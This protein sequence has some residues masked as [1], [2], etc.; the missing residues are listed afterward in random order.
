MGDWET[1]TKYNGSKYWDF[2]GGDA[3]INVTQGKSLKD[4]KIDAVTNYC[5]NCKGFS[6]GLKITW[7]KN[8]K[9]KPYKPLTNKSGKN[10]KTISH[11]YPSSG[12]YEI[13]FYTHHWIWAIIIPIPI[14]AHHKFNITV[15]QCRSH[16]YTNCALTTLTNKT[17]KD[18]YWYDSC[19]RKE[20]IKEKCKDEN[21]CTLNTCKNKKCN[22]TKKCDGSTCELN[23]T[24]GSDWCEYCG[25][26]IEL[27]CKDKIDNDC[28]SKVDLNDSDC[29]LRYQCE[30]GSQRIGDVNNDDEINKNDSEIVSRI[31]RGIL[32]TPKT[33]CCGDVNEDSS[34]DKLDLN[35]IKG[36]AK[37]LRE[38]FPRG[39]TCDKKENCTDGMDNDCDKRVDTTDSDCLNLTTTTSTSSTTTSIFTSTTTSSIFTSSTSTSTY[40]TTTT[41]KEF[42]I[43]CEDCRINENCKCEVVGFPQGPCISGFWRIFE[44][45]GH[46]LSNKTLTKVI[47]SSE[48]NYIEYTPVEKGKIKG[49]IDCQNPPYGSAEDY[50]YT[51]PLYLKCN[52]R[53]KVGEGCACTFTNCELGVF[54]LREISGDPLKREFNKDVKNCMNTGCPIGFGHILK[55]SGKIEALGICKSPQFVSSRGIRIVV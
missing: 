37:G 6:F 11:L 2:W 49:R 4:N 53:C 40:T 46:P 8:G 10:K 20:E 22:F 47:T 12:T 19:G 25:S 43:F 51:G 44:V 45:W 14:N 48:D 31:I 1:G 36:F 15:P 16:N 9:T 7:K 38:C 41:Q 28:D 50:A 18:I 24:K 13:D 21:P 5:K 27:A 30:G 23:D 32:P 34:I 42:G 39:Y 35:L 29:K 17:R 26:K 54:W 55:S 33:I 52:D 3:W